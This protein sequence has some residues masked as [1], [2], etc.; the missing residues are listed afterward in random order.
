MPFTKFKYSF[1]TPQHIWT[2]FLLCDNAGYIVQAQY[3]KV[4]KQDSK[5]VTGLSLTEQ[6]M[7]H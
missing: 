3:V 2:H 4:A 1:L 7:L 6:L 5:E